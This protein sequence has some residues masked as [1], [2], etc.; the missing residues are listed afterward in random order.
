M[1]KTKSGIFWGTIPN[2]MW[3]HLVE[4]TSLNN[5]GFK[6]FLKLSAALG[7]EGGDSKWVL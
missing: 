4:T 7:F 6:G 3:H 1:L 2:G 5:S